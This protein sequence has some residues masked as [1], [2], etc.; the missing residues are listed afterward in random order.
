[1]ANREDQDEMWQNVAL[2]LSLHCFCFVKKISSKKEGFYHLEIITC[3][4][5]IYAMYYSTFIVLKQKEKF[6]GT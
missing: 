3:D 6:T 2:H 1:M 5:S 4:P